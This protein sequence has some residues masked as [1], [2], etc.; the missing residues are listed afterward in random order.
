[1]A[2]DDDVVVVPAEARE[3]DD[4]VEAAVFTVHEVMNFDAVGGVAAVD[5]ARSMVPVRHGAP[6]SGRSTIPNPQPMLLLRF[7]CC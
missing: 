4:E 2:V 7:L 5:G 1:V 6:D 3:V